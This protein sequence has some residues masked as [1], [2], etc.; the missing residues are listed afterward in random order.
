MIVVYDVT[1]KDSFDNVRRWMT[2]IDNNCDTGSHSNN[3]GGSINSVNRILVGNKCDLINEIQ[4][5]KEDGDQI[6]AQFKVPHFWTSAKE[7][8]SVND[9]FSRLTEMA[10]NTQMH[11]DRNSQVSSSQQG[12][13]NNGKVQVGQMNK[14]QKKDGCC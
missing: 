5:A 4:V 6:A 7:N 9:M 3:S 10:Y 2:E 8:N 12:R 14:K 13:G 1:D 11:K